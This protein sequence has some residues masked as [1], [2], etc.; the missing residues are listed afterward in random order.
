[1]F[2]NLSRQGHHSRA[3]FGTLLMLGVAFGTFAQPVATVQAATPACVSSSPAGNAYTVNACIS[4]PADGATMTGTQTVTATVS[5]TGTNPGVSRA[6]FFLRGA[7]L[8]TDTSSPYTFQ[9][10]TTDFV[11]GAAV[12]EVEMNMRDGFASTHAPVTVTF[13]NGITTPPVNT[14]TFTPK[15]PA[16][17]AGAGQPLIVTAAGDGASGEANETVATNIIAGYNPDMVLYLGDVYEKGTLTEF[18]NW[19]GNS[20]TFYGQFKNKTNP[21]VG[22]HEYE[23]NQAPGYFNYW[24]NI[25]HY[26][27]YND[28]GWH[29]IALDSTSQYGQLTP[30]TPQFDWLQNDL[31]TNTQPCTLAYFHHPTF[32]IG[33]NGDT[34]RMNPVWAL[35]NTW[36]VDL[37][38]NGH[39]HD[40]QRWLPLDAN[41]NPSP[42]GVT[43][44]V[45]GTG[46]HGVQ[47]FVR[48]DGRVVKQ[49]G[50][51]PEG[52]GALKLAL[53]AGSAT[54]EFKNGSGIQDSG[55]VSCAPSSSD[56]TPPTK[57]AGLTATPLGANRVDLNW[58]P[59]TDN[60]GVV[61]YDLT[62]NNQF[63]CSVPGSSTSYADTTAA[64]STAYTYT[65]QARDLAGNSSPPSD[66][67]S[68]TTPSGSGVPLFTDGF[69]SG[70]LTG[71][72]NAG[73]VVQGTEVSGGSFAARATTTTAADWAWH[74]ITAQTNV[75]YRLKFNIVS[76]GA[77][78]VY[79]MK[80]RTATGTSI[81]GLYVDSSGRLSYRNDAGAVTV[82]SPKT[83]SRAAWHELQVHYVING[84]SGQIETW[85]DGA[86]VTEL[87]KTD[88]F[89]TTPIGRIPA[90]S[91]PF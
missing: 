18:K 90:S 71:W 43:E 49:I 10:A 62:R 60:V 14:N 47:D 16:P 36:G 35:F 20:S 39:D 66:P 2:G 44:F 3:F 51:V 70:D 11:D 50:T 83:V 80:V 5:V 19:Y 68:A 75:Y 25:P 76:Q 57:P 88:N 1:M 37:V 85:L 28:A 33:P 29:F 67:A 40:Y 89:G 81:G 73:M 22:N 17:A 13:S 45:V 82:V 42:T 4:A 84:L 46:G 86:K 21:V 15:T 9:L 59:A 38:L 64:P 55:S 78:S 54:Y 32:S 30:G 24:D 74:P 61:S 87:S 52:I 34:T 58:Q 26:Y 69:E 56:V 77:N 63:L 41:G 65:I 7:Y 6:V 48:T 27:S 53:G 8:L 23:G 72:T 12:L 91:S 79:L 31:S